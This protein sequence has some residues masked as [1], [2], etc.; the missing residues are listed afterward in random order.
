MMCDEPMDH[1]PHDRRFQGQ[2]RNRR[3]DDAMSPA[4]PLR[5]EDD[6]VDRAVA[7]FVEF[8]EGGRP[9]PP[10][11][12][13]LTEEQRIEVEGAVQVFRLHRGS[14]RSIDDPS[15]ED[16]TPDATPGSAVDAPPRDVVIGYHSADR[17]WATWLALELE[18]AGYRCHT[19]AFDGPMSPPLIRWLDHPRLL[20]VVSNAYLRL[21][22]PKT[23]L[24]S[25]RALAN[26]D[27]VVA[28]RVD[29]CELGAAAPLQFVDLAG[30]DASA[31]R[32]ALLQHLSRRFGRAVP[33]ASTPRFTSA[34]HYFWARQRSAQS[35]LVTMLLRDA[36]VLSGAATRLV[37]RSHA[38]GPADAHH[39]LD[40]IDADPAKGPV[41]TWCRSVSRTRVP[42]VMQ[43]TIRD[44][45]RS[46]DFGRCRDLAADLFAVARLD[47][48]LGDYS[49]GFEH[50]QQG[51]TILGVISGNSHDEDGLLRWPQP[52]ELFVEAAASALGLSASQQAA[53]RSVLRLLPHLQPDPRDL[54]DE[55]LHSLVRALSRAETRTVRAVASRWLVTCPP[56]SASPTP[57][58]DARLGCEGHQAGTLCNTDGWMACPSSR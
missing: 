8:L 43:A 53:I 13:G 30:R 6:P 11:L 32:T 40:V 3:D 21:D 41:L 28:V 7:Q 47:A 18:N 38:A 51:A 2:L 27:R 9:T 34:A 12:L 24:L 36:A 50:W 37:Y 58:S 55:D 10:S 5:D 35:P 20:N 16:P 52:D 46:Q 39:A 29:D 17:G 44:H 31:A 57:A 19:E 33:A 23:V 26:D 45:L 1:R 4:D 22:G 49:R 25:E 54:L 48:Q 42:L 15:N 14:R 56:S